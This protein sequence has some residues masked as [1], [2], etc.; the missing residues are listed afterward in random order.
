MQDCEIFIV[1]DSPIQLIILEKVLKN[2]GFG[3]QAFSGGWPLVDA[4]E[5]HQPHLIISDINMPELN[6]FELMQ[7]VQNRHQD[8]EIPFFFMSSKSDPAIEKRAREAGAGAVLP[9]PF[10]SAMLFEVIEQLLNP[11]GGLSDCYCM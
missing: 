9:K 10:S 7:E 3:I 4:L 11:S 5:H 2:E 1:D 6:G 8:P